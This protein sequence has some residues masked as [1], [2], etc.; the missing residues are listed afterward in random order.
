ME[1]IL[2]S[3]AVLAKELLHV[4]RARARL[5]A[6]GT[7]ALATLLL[8]SFAGGLNDAALRENSAGYLWIGILLA[9]TLAL[10]EG[11][12]VESGGRGLPAAGPRSLRML[13]S[14]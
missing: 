13:W 14:R 5:V 6:T 11:L 2:E 4:W 9:S 3:R 10:G 1:L 7:F 12:R 8:F